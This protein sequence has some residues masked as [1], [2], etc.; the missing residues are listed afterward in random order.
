M[1]PT[2]ANSRTKMIEN[3]VT[4]GAEDNKIK[5]L[6]LL[7]GS[8]ATHFNLSLLVTISLLFFRLLARTYLFFPTENPKEHYTH[9]S[10]SARV[11]KVTFM[12][13]P[14]KGQIEMSN[15]L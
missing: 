3:V 1:T 11:N 4:F 14:L 13:A 12:Q 9:K 15:H 2:Q 7:H 10:S 5:K 6:K 8:E